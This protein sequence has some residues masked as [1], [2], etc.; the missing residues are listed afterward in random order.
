VLA[1]DLRLFIHIRVNLYK[2]ILLCKKLGLVLAH[3]LI[4]VIHHIP[5]KFYK[6]FTLYDK[7]DPLGAVVIP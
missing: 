2:T 1:I 7:L 4:G 6:A 5:A 3:R